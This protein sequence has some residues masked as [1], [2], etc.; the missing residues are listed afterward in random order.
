MSSSTTRLVCGV[1][2]GWVGRRRHD[3]QSRIFRCRGRCRAKSG[4][5][6]GCDAAEWV[7]DRLGST[8][9]IG[10]TDL[11]FI[12]HYIHKAAELAG[13]TL[14]F[15]PLH[16]RFFRLNWLPELST[17]H[18]RPNWSY[19]MVAIQ[20]GCCEKWCGVSARS[21]RPR[22]SSQSRKSLGQ[23]LATLRNTPQE[24]AWKLVPCRLDDWLQRNVR[25]PTVRQILLQQAECNPF[26]PRRRP[27][28][29]D[30]SCTPQSRAR[31]RGGTQR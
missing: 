14:K 31:S 28:S 2:L 20:C 22:K 12:P 19:R 6:D 7:L 8:G 29:V 23:V 30:T 11:A 4:R 25:N 24:E 17:A 21:P 1:I 10:N 26:M 13:V 3:G 18:C 16:K 27:R 5:P 9:W 15:A